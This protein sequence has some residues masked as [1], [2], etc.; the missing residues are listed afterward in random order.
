[1]NPAVGYVVVPWFKRASWLA[2][3]PKQRQ[4][5]AGVDDGASWVVLLVRE[6]ISVWS[7][8]NTEH[9]DYPAS[10]ECG[11]LEAPITDMDMVLLRAHYRTPLSWRVRIERRSAT[12][13]CVELLKRFA[14]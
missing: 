6:T 9:P 1:M 14:K 3:K 7:T 11:R 4:L 5:S 2:R 13:D 10:T 12:T 8:K